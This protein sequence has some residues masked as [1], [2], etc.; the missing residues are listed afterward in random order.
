MSGSCQ[1]NARNFLHKY[2]DHSKHAAIRFITLRPQ[3]KEFMSLYILFLLKF[4]ER[5]LCT[6]VPR[7][8]IN[9]A[10][11]QKLYDFQPNRSSYFKDRLGVTIKIPKTAELTY[12]CFSDKH[13][14]RVLIYISCVISQILE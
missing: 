8:S 13:L 2:L 12:F 4:E 9:L 11:S 3:K 1:S 6:K 7:G 5:G 14:Y 10:Q